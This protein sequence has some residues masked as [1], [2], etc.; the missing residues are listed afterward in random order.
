MAL[1][2]QLIE[3]YRRRKQLDADARSQAHDRI[4]NNLLGEEDH[5]RHQL[6]DTRWLAAIG[7]GAFAY[8]AYCYWTAPVMIV[9]GLECRL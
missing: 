3:Q 8:M 6:T 5:L 1:V 9:A 4:I 7:W 2:H